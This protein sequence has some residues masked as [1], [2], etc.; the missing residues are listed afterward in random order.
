M[1]LEHFDQ[2]LHLAARLVDRGDYED[3]MIVMRPWVDSDLPDFNKSI[4]CI[5]LAVVSEHLGREADA[6]A[7][8]D[9]G[10][11]YERPLGRFFATEKKAAHL[12]EKGRTTDSLMLYE[13]LLWQTSLTAED[14]QR[15]RHNIA[16]LKARRSA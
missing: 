1:S 8:Y 6:L 14:E 11:G 5:N 4:V 15:I 7:W 3:A 2:S 12:A 10:I 13:T 9:R 16:A